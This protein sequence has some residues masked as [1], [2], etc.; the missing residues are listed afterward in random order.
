MFS[1]LRHVHRALPILADV[2]DGKAVRIQGNEFSPLMGGLC[3]AARQH[4]PGAGSENQTPLIRVGER[5]K[6]VEAGPGPSPGLRTTK[7][8][9]VM[10]EH[11]P[12]PCSV[13][14]GGPLPDM[15]QLN[16]RPR[17]AQTMKPRRV[18]ARKGS[19]A[20]SRL[21]VGASWSPTTCATPITHPPDPP[22]S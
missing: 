12:A 4:R 15:H 10:A 5:V 16:A 2:R 19:T 8:K 3:A 11:G 9:G 1:V 7:L 20:P 21:G 13:N 14:R 18:L 22:T 17:V 6:E